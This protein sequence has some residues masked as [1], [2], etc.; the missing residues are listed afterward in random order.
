[1]NVGCE[2]LPPD[3]FEVKE[4]VIYKDISSSRRIFS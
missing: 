3:V 2:Q 1:M 4:P